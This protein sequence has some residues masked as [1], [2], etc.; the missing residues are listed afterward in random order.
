[1]CNISFNIYTAK[2]DIWVRELVDLFN[3]SDTTSLLC[4]CLLYKPPGNFAIDE[5]TGFPREVF[6]AVLVFCRQAIMDQSQYKPADM[7]IN[8]S[9]W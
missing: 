8:R 6:I 3:R 5:L 9:K 7:D 4:S 1:M 2:S